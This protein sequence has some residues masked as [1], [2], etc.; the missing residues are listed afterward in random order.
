MNRFTASVPASTSALTDQM[1]SPLP[2]IK[3]EKFFTTPFKNAV[4]TAKTC[5]ASKGIVRDEKINLALGADGNPSR[6]TVIAK[7]IYDAGHH[8][9]LQHASFQ[10]SMTGV[11]RQFIWSFLHAH[12]FYNSEQ[13]SQRYVEVKHENFFIP[14]LG[15]EAQDIYQEALHAQMAAYRELCQKLTPVAA[16]EFFR[17]FPARAKEPEKWAKDI[18]KKAQEV[19]RYA[20][21]VATTAYL[22]HTISGLTLLRYYKMMRAFDVPLEQQL[23][24]TEM[25]RQLLE[26]DVHYRLVLDE[27]TPI[28]ETPEYKFLL[29]HHENLTAT[30]RKTFRDDFDRSLDGKVSKLIDWK[31][32]AEQ[33]LAESVREVFGLSSSELSDHDAIELALNPKY[34]TA[35]G[36]SLVATTHS[37]LSRALFHA[38][39]TFRKKLSHAADSQ[40]QRHRMTPASRPILAAQFSDEPD[41]ITPELLK[42]DA[43]CE[44]IY[45][46]AMEKSW[47]AIRRLK[48][49][50]V[51]DEFALYLLPNAVSIRF[52]ESADLLNLHHKM[53]MRLCY[54]AQEEIWRA[55]VDEAMQITE[56]HPSIGKYL[57]PPCTIRNLA[58]IR[59][60]CPEGE[61]YCGVKVWRLEMKDYERVI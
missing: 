58:G 14:K 56:R 3:L 15:S 45:I 11:S 9:T 8:T 41:F 1:L 33:T 51:S 25:V 34:N 13:V 10:F 24:V 53:E 23:V 32:N 22:Y 16:S 50:G 39:Y 49:L 52:T 29:A 7:S 30:T 47:D 2:E 21:P 60:T 19:A 36:E 37:K 46:E 43:A 17:V 38:H 42:Q 57:L 35:L 44:A 61:R 48:K 6:D 26:M 54:N 20:L 27:P 12:P 28:E 55:S 4:A 59:P 31:A 40:D 18:Q 5:Y